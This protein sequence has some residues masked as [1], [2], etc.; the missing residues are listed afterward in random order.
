MRDKADG[1]MNGVVF[2]GDI[3][4][5]AERDVVEEFLNSSA[6]HKPTTEAGKKRMKTDP[7]LKYIAEIYPGKTLSNVNEARLGAYFG[8]RVK[9]KNNVTTAEANKILKAF[10][11]AG[12]SNGGIAST[13]CSRCK[14]R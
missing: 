1:H 13:E 2:R 6:L 8:I 4:A 3:S 5:Q 14:E 7:L 10:Q 12:F 9:N 11:N